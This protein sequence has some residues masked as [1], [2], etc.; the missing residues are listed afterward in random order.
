MPPLARARCRGPPPAVT[1]ARA[2]ETQ[3]VRPCTSGTAP[4][5]PRG[6]VDDLLPRAFARHAPSHQADRALR[7]GP[8]DALRCLTTPEQQGQREG[9]SV[10]SMEDLSTRYATLH[11]A[12]MSSEDDPHLVAGLFAFV[13][14]TEA[15]LH[16][17][18]FTAWK[19]ARARWSA[20]S[21]VCR[22]FWVV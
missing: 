22:Y 11:P 19:A 14:D 3:T 8:F 21:R 2:C 15:G 13:L 4:T 9:H 1:Q 10:R 6:E 18:V 20:S 7:P 17:R 12:N 16:P 5:S